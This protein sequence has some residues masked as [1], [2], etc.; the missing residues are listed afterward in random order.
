M[1]HGQGVLYLSDGRSVQTEWNRDLPDLEKSTVFTT[2]K[3]GTKL[4]RSRYVGGILLEI[5]ESLLHPDL[6]YHGQG[7]FYYED[8]SFFMG[9]WDKGRLQDYQPFIYWSDRT[10]KY[11]TRITQMSTDGRFAHEFMPS[12]QTRY[13][14]K[15]WNGYVEGM[16]SQEY[17]CIQN[18]VY[19]YD[20][21]GHMIC[22]PANAQYSMNPD[23]YNVEYGYPRL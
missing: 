21:L 4:R 20:N 14:P 9:I 15:N 5:F 11:E 16:F 19:Y 6:C 18:P 23:G 17:N 22:G 12:K 3:P 8:D 7:I 13:H 10:V 2:E 1:K